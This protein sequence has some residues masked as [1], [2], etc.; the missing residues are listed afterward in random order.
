MPSAAAAFRWLMPIS[1]RSRLN[2]LEKSVA[3]SLTP[4]IFI[5]PVNHT[6]Y[7]TDCKYIF[8]SVPKKFA[9]SSAVCY[10]G[11]NKIWRC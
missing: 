9:P 5:Q 10:N 1:C 3:N 4:F 7:N 11:D 6:L 8:R 2:V